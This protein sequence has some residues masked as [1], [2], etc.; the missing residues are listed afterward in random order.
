MQSMIKKLEKEIVGYKAIEDKYRDLER[1]HNMMSKEIERLNGIIR[2]N[3][4]EI[5]DG[6]IKFQRLESTISE[7]RNI[8]AKVKDL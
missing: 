4:N 6:Q 7:Y 1:N 2:N 5:R 3:N 8:E